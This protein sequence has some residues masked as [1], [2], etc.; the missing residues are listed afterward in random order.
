MIAFCIIA[1]F[2]WGIL[3]Y[4][5]GFELKEHLG[6]YFP[7]CVGY[8]LFTVVLL[9]TIGTGGFWAAG[10]AFL[11]IILVCSVF[12]PFMF[13]TLLNALYTHS[14]GRPFEWSLEVGECLARGSLTSILSLLLYAT[15]IA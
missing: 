7:I 3:G 5:T 6:M 12:I 11:Q 8:G 9:C 1:T 15:F 13:D 14:T 2:I 10:T 4:M